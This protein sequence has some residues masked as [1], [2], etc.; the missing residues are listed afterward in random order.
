MYHFS[1][2]HFYFIFCQF[3]KLDTNEAVAVIGRLSMRN[4][5]NG[6]IWKHARDTALLCAQVSDSYVLSIKILDDNF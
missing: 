2:Q 4:K 3:E 6:R 5:K 1:R